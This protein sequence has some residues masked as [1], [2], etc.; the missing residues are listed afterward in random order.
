MG[1]SPAVVQGTSNNPII[2]DYGPY[3][4][5]SDIITVAVAR[6]GAAASDPRAT[7]IWN[8]LR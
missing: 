7:L 3:D 8:E 5:T 6:E 4:G 2:V 1:F